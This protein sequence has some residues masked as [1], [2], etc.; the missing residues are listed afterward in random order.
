MAVCRAISAASPHR[1]SI[2]PL[3]RPTFSGGL[4]LAI[5]AGGLGEGDKT[6]V[7]DLRARE[8]GWEQGK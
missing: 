5:A 6:G 1:T 7:Q 4:G 8:E 3:P 2:D